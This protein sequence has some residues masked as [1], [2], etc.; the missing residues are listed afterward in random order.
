MG[1]ITKG[2]ASHLA[3]PIDGLTW[4]GRRYGATFA[5]KLSIEEHDRALCGQCLRLRELA[6]MRIEKLRHET[7]GL[8][9]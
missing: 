3:G 6:K 7:K 1:N 8:K 4:C 5:C 2:M 9:L